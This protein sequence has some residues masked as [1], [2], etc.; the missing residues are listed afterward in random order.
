MKEYSLRRAHADELQ[1][2]IAI[3]DEACELYATAGLELEL[4]N[5]HP[6]VVAEQL[7]WATAIEQGLAYVAV[8]QEGAPIG[9]AVLAYVDGEPYLDQIAVRPDYMRRGVGTALLNHALSW[10]GDRPLW[11]TTYA[12]L[13]WN[14]PYYEQ[15]GFVAVPAEECVAGILT[16]LQEQRA[17]LPDP[18][19]RIAMVYQTC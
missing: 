8:N 3:D 6:F 7:R 13:P 15:R 14:K 5:D 16:I 18:D 9:F 19:Q 12:H 10:S 1:T 4:E 2:L 17:A 11:L